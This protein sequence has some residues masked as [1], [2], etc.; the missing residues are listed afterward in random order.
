MSDITIFNGI[1]SNEA[2]VIDQLQHATNYKVY[3]DQDLVSR[4]AGITGLSDAKLLRAG[5]AEC[6]S[7]PSGAFVQDFRF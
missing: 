5:S 2:A 3:S 4:A 6:V 7:G 1:F